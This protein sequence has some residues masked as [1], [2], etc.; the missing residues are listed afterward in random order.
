MT[1]IICLLCLT[2]LRVQAQT[3]EAPPPP[4]HL[5]Q[6]PLGS[7][8]WTQGF[9][10][11]RFK[12]CKDSTIPHLWSVYTDPRQGHALQNFDIAAGIHIGPPFQDGDFYKLI[13]AMAAVYASTHDPRLDSTMDHAIAIIAKAQRADG[14]LHT[15]VL[16][17]HGAHSAATHRLDFEAYNFGHLMTAACVHYRATGKKTLLVVAE[18]AA[19]YL[20]H[21][22]SA[23]PGAMAL[24]NICPSHYMGLVE[25]Y[26]TTGVR[27]YLELA[28]RLIREHGAAGKGTDQNQDRIPFT[29]QTTA[30]GHAVRA[31]YLYAGA[32]DVFSENGDSAL[33]RPLLPI[34]TD[35]TSHKLYVTGGC[36][37]L[38]DGISPMGTAYDPAQI[39]TVHQAYGADYQLPNRTAHNETCAAVGA[40]LWNWRMFQVTGAARYMDLVELELYNGILSGVSLDGNRFFYTNPLR[41][42]RSAPDTLRWAGTRQPYITLSDCCPPNA[43]RTIAEASGY[44][45]SRDDRGVWVNLY[46]GSTLSLPGLRMEQTT[47]YPWNGRIVLSIDEAPADSMSLYLR[48][49]GWCSFADAADV[50]ATLTVDGAAVPVMPGSY[51]EVRRHW[52]PG[53]SVVLSLSMPV[54]LLQANPQVESDLGQVAVKRGPIVYCLESTDVP[55]V[56]N[57]LDVAVGV[58]WKEVPFA[59]GGTYMI[60]LEGTGRLYPERTWNGLYQ[61]VVLGVSTGTNFRLIP[62]FAWGNRGASDMTVWIRQMDNP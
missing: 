33:W 49:P 51:A 28:D 16:I 31:N 55:D 24:N 15:P 19:G 2:A 41:V 22:D 54:T 57:I 21:Y 29:R 18:R 32:A 48:I 9:W 39:Q 3:A 5:Q 61:T 12:V 11:D 13:E 50:G 30:V 35:V 1:R 36:G 4:A 47:D 44:A 62:Y 34:W 7:V 23:H 59:V 26:R 56:H 6:L 53:D 46:G 42:L 27:A 20:I 14:Y 43:A 40:L 37:A 10:A 17:E 45:Y 38:Y 25:L 58:E 52:R 60:K 8:R